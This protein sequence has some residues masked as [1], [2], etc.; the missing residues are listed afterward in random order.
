MKPLHILIWH[1]Q[2]RAE[3]KTVL[4]C[5]HFPFPIKTSC[6][7]GESRSLLQTHT[8]VLQ[9]WQLSPFAKSEQYSDL[10]CGSFFLIEGRSIIE[11]LSENIMRLKSGGGKLLQDSAGM[12]VCSSRCSVNILQKQLL[13]RPSIFQTCCSYYWVRS[14]EHPEAASDGQALL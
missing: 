10:L 5:I 13:I 12:W 3:H 11:T 9:R 6:W 1:E 14:R 7:Q 8:C 4:S 2:T